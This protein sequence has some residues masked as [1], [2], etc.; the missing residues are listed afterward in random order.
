MNKKV[1]YILTALT[2]ILGSY[3]VY[4]YIF[5]HSVTINNASAEMTISAEKLTNSY[6][7]NQKKANK[8]YKGKVIEV[9]GIIK[10]I[11]FINKT[12]TII[13]QSDHKNFSVLCDMQF[14]S[15]EGLQNLTVGQKV[16]VKGICKGFLHDVILL[17][18]MLI[19]T[20]N[21]E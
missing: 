19:N 9:Y 13:L 12:K 17:N 3:G 8:L 1:F 5:R 2:L 7:T 4:S 14:D 21:N 16:T 15:S 18:C 11:T 20:K 6:V 10:E